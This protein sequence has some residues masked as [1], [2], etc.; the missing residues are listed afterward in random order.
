M[1]HPL[2]TGY[3]AKQFPWVCSHT[4]ISQGCCENLAPVNPNLL[5]FTQSQ[6]YVACSESQ[7]LDANSSVLDSRA[8]AGSQQHFIYLF[9]LHQHFNWRK[10]GRLV[11]RTRKGLP[12]E[13]TSKF[14]DTGW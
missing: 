14:S 12:E 8:K 4:A 5:V 2:G 7:I 6:R 13:V 3:Q 10:Q 9:F 1:E 11:Q